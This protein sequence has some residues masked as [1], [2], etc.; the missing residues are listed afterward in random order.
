MAIREAGNNAFKRVRPLVSR[1]ASRTGLSL[2]TLFFKERI[3]AGAEAPPWLG[4]L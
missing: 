3:F 2:L 1:W 4:S